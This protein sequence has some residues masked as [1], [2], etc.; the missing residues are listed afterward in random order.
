MQRRENPDIQYL[1]Y[2]LQNFD[3]FLSDVEYVYKKNYKIRDYEYILHKLNYKTI[4]MYIYH[5]K[6]EII[7]KNENEFE[8]TINLNN[9]RNE[10]NYEI[11]ED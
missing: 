7:K 8:V 2:I 1:K 4:F 6:I 10:K 3:N 5:N 11:Y 9:C